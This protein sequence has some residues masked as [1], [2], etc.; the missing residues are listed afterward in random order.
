MNLKGKGKYIGIGVSVITIAVFA[1]IYGPF[2]LL[3]TFASLPTYF[4]LFF[5]AA[6][7]LHILSFMFWATRIMVLS[8]ANGMKVPFSK[9]LV[10]V[11]S[12]LFAASL[13]PGYVGG[14]PVRIKKLVDYGASAGTATA[15]ALGERGF[16]SIFFVFV[17]LLVIITGIEIISGEL[18]L[19]ATIGIAVLGAFI[20]FL[21]LSMRAH[22]IAGHINSVVQWFLDRAGIRKR[23]LKN[24]MPDV[25]GEVQSYSVSTR[26]IFINKPAY[27][28]AGITV[29]S[30]MWLS[31]FS[32][33]LFLLLGFGVMPS[34]IY[35][36]F[37]QVVLVLISLIPLTPGSAGLMEILMFATFSIFLSHSQL[38]AFVIIWRFI[39]FYFNIILGSF[40]LHKIVTK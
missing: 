26:K 25:A 23:L 24:E 31:D 1:F 34:L 19:Y 40:A 39:T 12:S 8:R 5:L 21:F 38:V 36:I 15:I 2:N 4:I 9:S 27:L 28:A 35:I 37:I 6:L 17:F 16:D 3:R 32:V 11:V 22:K 20:V 7:C 29:T 18:R 33:P 10:A 30:M 14:E 13:T